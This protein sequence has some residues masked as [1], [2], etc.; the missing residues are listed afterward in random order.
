MTLSRLNLKRPPPDEDPWGVLRGT[1]RQPQALTPGFRQWSR[2]VSWERPFD[3]PVPLPSGPPAR[4]LR[5][6]ANYIRKLP[7]SERDLPEW[8]LAI[9]MLIDAA[10]D[11]GPM[12]F[13]KMGM[14]RAINRHVERVFDPDRKDAHWGRRKLARDR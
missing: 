4:T 6:A 3:Q 13:A 1:I 10:E 9:Q 8:R 7:Q 11:R 2:V 12:L 5:D 14:L